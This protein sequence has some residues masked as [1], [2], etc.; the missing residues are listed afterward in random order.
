MKS[1][2]TPWRCEAL[3]GPPPKDDRVLRE[4]GAIIDT[5]VAAPAGLRAKSNSETL[6]YGCHDPFITPNILRR[7]EVAVLIEG[8]V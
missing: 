4:R 8:S 6:V 5:T 1:L 3:S 2:L 7:N